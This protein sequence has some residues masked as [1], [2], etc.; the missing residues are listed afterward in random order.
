MPIG[1]LCGVYCILCLYNYNTSKMKTWWNRLFAAASCYHYHI[2]IHTRTK[3]YSEEF[4]EEPLIRKVVISSDKLDDCATYTDFL[5]NFID[6]RIVHVVT[7]NTTIK[8]IEEYLTHCQDYYI[9]FTCKELVGHDDGGMYDFL[10]E[11]Y[12]DENN[13]Y[14]LDKGD[15]NIYLM[16]DGKEYTKFLME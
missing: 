15:Y 1:V 13:I 7:K 9:Q 14:F 2:D 8:M 6:I 11:K 16:P 12:Q 4:W 10:K 5:L 3:L